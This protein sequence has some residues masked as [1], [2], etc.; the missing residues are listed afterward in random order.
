M[1]RPA[2]LVSVG[3]PVYNGENFVAEAIQ[4]VMA[5]SF[6]DWEL[7]ISDNA[8]TDRT[9]SLCRQFAAHD[10]RIS[11]FQN[12]RNLGVAPNYNRVFEL[13]RGRYFAWL[14]HDDFWD[15]EFL[16]RCLE[17][18]ERDE[19]LPLVFPKVAFVDAQ[20]RPLRGQESDLSVFGATAVSRV[21]RLLQL[22][23]RSNDIFWSQFGLI[24]RRTLEQ[25]HLMN[26]YNGSDQVLLLE[27]AL[28]GAL[29][30]IDAELFF[31]REHPQASTIRRN[32]DARDRARFQYADDQRV[33]VFPNWRLLGEHLLCIWSSS[34]P[35]AGKMQCTAE[36]L[37]RFSGRWKDLVLELTTTSLDGLRMLPALLGTSRIHSA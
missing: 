20:R 34:L 10:S 27:I 5:Q 2:P 18:L 21:C 32:W 33:L 15:P 6:P 17:E 1:A 4:C 13:S 26:P 11:V 28:R 12:E 16:A 23:R 22:E 19:D 14:A 7:I 9:V 36:I 35:A 8:S 24:R 30:Q 29:K 37:R 3:L 25:T 31:R